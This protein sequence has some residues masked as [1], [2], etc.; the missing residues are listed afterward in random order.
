MLPKVSVGR[1]HSAMS[2]GVENYR[3]LVG[4]ELIDEILDLAKSLQGVR[5]CHLNSTPFGG[6]V[7]ELL[8]RYIPMAQALGLNVD[9]RL[10]HGE[11]AFFSVTKSFHNALQ[12]GSYDLLDPE[13]MLYL[14]VNEQSARL[15]SVGYDVYIVHDPQP[16]AIRHFA[17]DRYAKWIWRCHIDSSSPDPG[18]SE[19]LRP[20]IEEYDAAVFTMPE[21]VLPDLN[22]SKTAFIAPAIDPLATKNMNLPLDLCKRAII[23]SGLDVRR[24]LLVQVSPF[25]LDRLGSCRLLTLLDG[26]H[27]QLVPLPGLDRSPLLVAQSFPERFGF[28]LVLP[29]ERNP[30]PALF[31]EAAG[32]FV[33]TFSGQSSLALQRGETPLQLTQLFE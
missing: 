20:Y 2:T 12:G 10:I 29:F 8:T 13:R 19:F 11:S 5:I 18:V 28:G 32:Q 30:A 6:G 4:D 7:A 24:P 15:M 1:F 22:V 31:V 21:F 27:L 23:D 16:A 14:Q 26:G 33:D 3:P 17:G 9:W 25:F